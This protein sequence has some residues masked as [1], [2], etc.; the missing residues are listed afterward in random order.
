M[1]L[2]VDRYKF[3]TF[4]VA[5]TITLSDG[6]PC[7]LHTINITDTTTGTVTVLNGTA[8]AAGTIALIVN[9]TSGQGTY[10]FDT[11]LS[12]GLRIVTAG[13]VK[14]CVSYTLI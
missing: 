3:G 2:G 1:S 10:R 4:S 11:E 14:G 6:T 7:V 9:G 13:N 5:G 12:T 8:A